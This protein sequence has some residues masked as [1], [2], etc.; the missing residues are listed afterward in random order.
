MGMVATVGPI[1]V[2][3]CSSAWGA[4]LERRGSSELWN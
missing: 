1:T 4:G 2:P 3:V